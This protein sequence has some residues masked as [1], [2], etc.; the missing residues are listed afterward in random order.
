MILDGNGGCPSSPFSERPC[1][2]ESDLCTPIPPS[3]SLSHNTHTHTHYRHTDTCIHRHTTD[4]YHTHIYRQNTPQTHICMHIQ[5]HTI[6]ATDTRTHA[7]RHTPHTYIY[8][9]K[10]TTHKY[11]CTTD[12]YPHIPQT[13]THASTP[14]THTPILAAGPGTFPGIT[15]SLQPPETHPCDSSFSFPPGS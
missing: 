1:L 13:L 15:S 10:H 14:H 2:E 7:F 6:D 9:Q 12:T 5:A 8:R 11:V 4:T 3:Q